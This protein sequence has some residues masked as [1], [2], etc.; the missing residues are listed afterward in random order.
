MSDN[1]PLALITGASSGIGFELA[2]QFRRHGYDLVIAA[3]DHAIDTAADSLRAAGARV[4][5]VRVDLR[6]A[7]G[8][9]RLYATATQD[10]RPLAAVALNAGVGRGGYFADTDL[11]QELDVIALNVQSTV[12]LT[13][14]VLPGMIERD[15]GKLLFTS[16]IAALMPGPRHAVYNAT[17]SFVQS[18]AEALREE[19][20]DHHITVTALLPGPT[21]TD[22]FRRARLLSSRMGQAPKD[23]PAEV[24]RQG[25]DALMQDKQQVVAASLASKGMGLAG[26]L[27]P[28]TVK[29]KAHD[30]FAGPPRA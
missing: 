7:E 30:V 12:H 1:P 17:K 9:E 18:F 24:A 13:K 15:D 23:D 26:R 20:R 4:H 11:A 8:V 16:S 14:L 21:D 19:L 25:V 22:F 27:L 3:E 6:A 10:G 28:D 5:P 2:D 29:A